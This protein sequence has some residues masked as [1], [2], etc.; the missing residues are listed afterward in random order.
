MSGGDEFRLRDNVLVTVLRSGR[1]NGGRLLEIE[2]TFPPGV[3]GPPAHLH[4]RETEEFT[5]LDGRLWVRIGRRR[6]HLEQ[7]QSASIPPGTV[8]AFANRSDA[9]VTFRAVSTPAGILEQIV[10]LQ[11][12]A[13]RTPVLRIARLNHGEDQTFFLAGLPRPAQRLLW[14]ALAALARDPGDRPHT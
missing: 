14:N 4:S 11:A 13:G 12:E 5:V 6:L 2:S 10:R 9:P 8:H 7:G 3:A 1:D